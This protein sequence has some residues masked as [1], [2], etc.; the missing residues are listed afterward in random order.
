MRI[1]PFKLERFFDQYEFK[2]PYL[3]CSSDCEALSIGDLLALEDGAAA[4]FHTH[5][6]GYTEARGAPSLRQEIA[7]LYTGITPDEVL[8]HAGAEEAIF[9]FMNAALQAGDHVLVHAPG[10]Q[11]LAEVATAIGCE[12]T[13]WQ[14]RED[15]D[16]ELDLDVLR[17]SIRPNTRLI[18][19]NCPHNPTGY[20]MS[21]DKQRDLIDIARQH[22]LLLFSD[23]VYRLLEHGAPTLPAACDLYENA[24][25]LGVM[26]K[27]FGLAGLRIGWLAT[28]NRDIYQAVQ[29]MKDY[30]TICSSA[31]SEF[32]AELALRQQQKIIARNQAIIAA[33]LRLLDAFFARYESLFRWR[34][35]KAGST[36]FPSIRFE[37]D[38]E[39][40][41][42]DVVQ[43]QGVLL[44]PSTQFDYGTRHFR[45][46]FG[47]RN[48]PQ[49]LERLEAYV[50]ARF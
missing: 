18:V 13:L 46:G 44:L 4:A 38:V 16:W 6:L 21:P 8:V 9:L 49:A 45:V 19:V 33:N 17:A 29:H 50:K 36:A 47:R 39:A 42:R 1:K 37:Q 3:L 23:E 15:D 30:T 11:S 20:L 10:Y 5:W 25:S 22:G 27:T 2:A 24:V 7:R 35:P 41:C 40:F 32:L 31:P 48:L 34:A 26:S 12:V 28:R 14:T 43:Q